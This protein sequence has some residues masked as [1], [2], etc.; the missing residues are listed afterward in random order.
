MDTHRPWIRPEDRRRTER[1]ALTVH[2]LWRSEAFAEDLP[3]AAAPAQSAA[4]TP[5]SRAA[6]VRLLACCRSVMSVLPGRAPMT[7]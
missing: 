4:G 3:A 7:A 2:D 5:P 6:T 1:E